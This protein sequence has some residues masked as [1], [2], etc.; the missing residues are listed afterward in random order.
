MIDSICDK[1][2]PRFEQFAPN[3]SLSEYVQ[4]K[5]AVSLSV[6]QISRQGLDKKKVCSL[7]NERFGNIVLSTPSNL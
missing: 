5:E 7:T 6:K 3:L 4:L 1:E 2:G